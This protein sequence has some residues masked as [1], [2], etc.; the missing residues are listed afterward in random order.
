MNGNVHGIERV[1]LKKSADLV[2]D[3]CPQRIAI[4]DGAQ[5]K[6]S[7]LVKTGIPSPEAKKGEK[8]ARQ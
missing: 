4:E 5:L 7:V 3:I 2:G 1:E 8:T 6:G